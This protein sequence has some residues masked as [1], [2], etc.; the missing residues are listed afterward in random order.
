MRWH[1]DYLI[2]YLQDLKA[3]PIQSSEDLEC[4]L[5][6]SLS[7]VSEGYI[8]GFGSSDCNCQSHLYWMQNN[9]LSDER[10]IDILLKYRIGRLKDFID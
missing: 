5:S 1:I 2:P 7:S 4:L 8:K 6:E 9:P 3:I 10:F